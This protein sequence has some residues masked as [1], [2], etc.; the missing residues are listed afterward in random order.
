MSAR[1]VLNLS[2]GVA[3]CAIDRGPDG[4]TWLSLHQGSELVLVKL[5][6]AS[7]AALHR[8][9]GK[10][11]AVPADGAVAAAAVN[12]A[13]GDGAQ[14]PEDPAVPGAGADGTPPAEGGRG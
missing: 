3:G 7:L 10:Q 12:D 6:P 1:I 8:A 11:L 5:S 2:N 9:L 4:G 14:P 13:P